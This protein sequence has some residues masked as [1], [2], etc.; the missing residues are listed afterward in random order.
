MPGRPP[1]QPHHSSWA[2][3]TCVMPAFVDDGRQPPFQPILVAVVD[4]HGLVIGQGVA[5]PDDPDSGVEQALQQAIAAPDGGFGAGSRPTAITIT[6]AELRPVVERILPG[7]PIRVGPS[8]DLEELF[9]SVPEMV[10]EA[11]G[12]GLMGLQSLLSGDIRPQDVASFFAACKPLYE[13][14]P[15]RRFVHEQCLF[16]ISSQALGMRRWCGCVIGQAGQ[17]YGVLLFPSRQDQERFIETAM[18]AA[19][20]GGPP[21]GVLPHQWAISFEPLDAIS[22]SLADEIAAHG[23]P[24]AA[25]DGYPVPLHVDPDLVHHPLGRVELARL[26]AVARALTRL[27]DNVPDLHDFWNWSG[28]EPLRRQYRLPVQDRG[29]VS[30]TLTLIPPEGVDRRRR[31]RCRHGDEP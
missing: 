31:G 14:Q 11:D 26:E 13:R 30:V 18:L 27:I 8:A 7:I 6:A 5:A 15:W 28:Q 21:M 12:P 17:S 10:A 23:W 9:S 1:R 19:Q 20:I 16:M 29:P 22:R 24:V 4:G 25:G 3:G 2:V